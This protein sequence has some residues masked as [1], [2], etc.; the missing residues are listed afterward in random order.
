MKKKWLFGL[1]TLGAASMLCGFDSAE[2]LDSLSEKMNEAGSAAEGV[3]AAMTLNLDATVDISDG[4]TSVPLSFLLNADCDYD[5]ALDPF[6][7]KMDMTMNLSGITGEQET[8]VQSYSV[9]DESGA[10]KTYSYTEDSESGEGEWSVQTLDDLNI[11]SLMEQTGG[12]TMNFSDL[13]EWGLTFELAPESAEIAGA[14]CYVLSTSLDSDT[15]DTLIRK[16]GEL[17]GEDLSSDSNVSL[18]LS[19]LT[20]LKIDLTYYVDAATYLPVQIHMDMNDSDFSTIETLVNAYLG[21][22][23]SDDAP[24]STA[25]LTVNDISLDMST[26]YGAAPE[27]TVPQEAL[28]AEADGETVSFGAYLEDSAVEN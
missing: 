13:E 9:T 25:S 17:T 26:S 23:S 15:L 11:A 7:M 12:L 20:G 3:T 19:L 2:T 16:S 5:I 18:A 14:E 21:T 1:L 4:T 28:E 22:A 10:M 27:I 6:A 24:A 8:K